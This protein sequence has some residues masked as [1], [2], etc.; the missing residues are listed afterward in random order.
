MQLRLNSL[1]RFSVRLEVPMC[2]ETL[3]RKIT[4]IFSVT[5]NFAV[6]R[7]TAIN[8]S[9]EDYFLQRIYKFKEVTKS[10]LKTT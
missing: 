3:V 5:S 4:E 9:R 2:S 8:Y 1:T 6:T 10:D 7:R